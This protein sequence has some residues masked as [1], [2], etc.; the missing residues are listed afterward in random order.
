V[1]DSTVDRRPEHL[2]ERRT[3]TDEIGDETGSGR[4]NP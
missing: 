1:A 4:R 3:T 2:D